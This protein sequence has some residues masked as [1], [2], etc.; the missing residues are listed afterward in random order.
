MARVQ[1]ARD[2]LYEEASRIIERARGESRLLTGE[3]II[4]P[5]SDLSGYCIGWSGTFTRQTGVI[6]PEAIQDPSHRGDADPAQL[7]KETW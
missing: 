4:P 1:A 2:E 6:L 7:I 3:G 5:P